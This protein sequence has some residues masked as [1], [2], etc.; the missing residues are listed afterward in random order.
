[1]PFTVT[2]LATALVLS[3]CAVPVT[4]TTRVYDAPVTYAA[5]PAMEYGTVRR[6]DVVETRLEPT[7]GGS[8][9]GAVIGGVVGN[10]I[11][12]GAGRA[13][14]TALGVFGGAVIG[15]NAEQQQAAA[16]SSTVYHVV[17]GF[18][19]GRTRSF[20]YHAL[21]GL[22]TGERVRLEGGVLMR[23]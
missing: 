3:A 18:D 7:G 12:H 20:D 16:N 19:N 5:V 6:I 4:R 14:A 22:H 17:V 2:G 13:A 8:V 10:Q 15:N 21:D 11:G 1:M 23:G 9:L